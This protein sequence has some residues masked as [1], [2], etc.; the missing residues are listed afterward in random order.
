MKKFLIV[1]FALAVLLVLA[2]LGSEVWWT[3]WKEGAPGPPLRLVS[4]I[5]GHGEAD[6]PRTDMTLVLWII[7][8][9]GASATYRWLPR[10][11]ARRG[12]TRG[13]RPA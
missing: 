12:A 7:A 5:R 9:V 3:L 8:V 10:A 4:A 2:V 6:D 1:T 11:L 13:N